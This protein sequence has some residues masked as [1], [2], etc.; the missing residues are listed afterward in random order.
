M[1]LKIDRKAAIKKVKSLVFYPKSEVDSFRAKIEKNFSTVFLPN[2]VEC[3]EHNYGGVKCDVLYPEV[4]SS[5]RIIIYV[6]GGSFVGGSRSSWR[7]FCASL[8]NASSCRVVVP[9]FRLAP[10]YPFPAGI[11]DLQS[12]F[13]M[14]YSEETV[15]MQLEHSSQGFFGSAPS[16]SVQII[17]AADGSGAS[18][19]IALLLKLRDKYRQCVKDLILFS[20]WLDLTSD[21]PIISGR[22]VS[23]EVLSGDALHRAV[24]M[25][26]YASNISNPHVSPLKADVEEFKGFPHVY[27]QMG[28]LEILLRD[29]ERFKEVLTKANVPVTMDVWPSMMY[30]FQ[31]ADEFLPESHLAVERIGRFIS[32]REEDEETKA[33]REESMKKNDMVRD[34]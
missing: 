33:E 17:L 28:G 26:T 30:M 23:D 6:H 21:N 2:R 32:L 8:A 12:V 22:H 16:E 25:Y 15:A 7:N 31:M 19:A 1:E 18:L 4:Y 11:E 34:E 5:R 10:S 9:E 20:P 13:R 24:D 3:M 14:V 27:I 29:A